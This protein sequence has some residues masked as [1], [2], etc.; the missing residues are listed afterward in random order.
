[1]R[2][3]SVQSGVYTGT[4]YKHVPFLAFPFFPLTSLSSLSFFHNFHTG[5]SVYIRTTLYQGLDY[6]EL[7]FLLIS[8][9]LSLG[10]FA[11]FPSLSLPDCPLVVEDIIDFQETKPTKHYQ[12]SMLTMLLILSETTLGTDRAG[13]IH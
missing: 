11:S 12:C 3:E 5:S 2:A 4:D 13:W 1:M 10:L 7:F 6:S 9:A 8:S